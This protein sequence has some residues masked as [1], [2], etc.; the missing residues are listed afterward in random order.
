MPITTH[1]IPFLELHIVHSSPCLLRE[2]AFVG[3]EQ[4]TLHTALLG[5]VLLKRVFGGILLDQLF[6]Y[7]FH[8]EGKGVVSV[9][10]PEQ[11]DL[12]KGREWRCDG[13]PWEGR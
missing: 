13:K 1:I 6:F 2:L 3:M 11:D 10:R 9:W 8:K 4:E 5:F 12:L 7:F